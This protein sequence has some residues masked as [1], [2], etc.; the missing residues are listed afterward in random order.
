MDEREQRFVFTGTR[1][2]VL[3]ALSNGWKFNQDY[4]LEEVLPSLSRQKMSNRRKKL[5]LD[6]AVHMDDSM[7][8]NA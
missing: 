5:E 7:C 3:K 1:P 6:F 8:H 2:L 4:F